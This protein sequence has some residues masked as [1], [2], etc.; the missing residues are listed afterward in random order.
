MSSHRGARGAFEA[1][2]GAEHSRQLLPG[3][4]G[5]RQQL[6]GIGKGTEARVARREVRLGLQPLILG[7]RRQRDLQRP[8]AA[9]LRQQL[10]DREAQPHAP[11]S[12]RAELVE[13]PLLLAVRD[14]LRRKNDPST[15]SGRTVK[16]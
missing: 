3:R 2:G 6:H 14:A 8:T 12:V 10:F 5:F 4:G 9:R 15:S 16:G 7:E 1:A 13:A 11:N